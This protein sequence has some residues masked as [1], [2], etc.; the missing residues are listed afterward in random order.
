MKLKL[1]S[2]TV[3]F[4]CSVFSIQAQNKIN[5]TKASKKIGANYYKIIEAKKKELSTRNLEDLKSLKEYKHFG[6]W[7]SYWRHRINSDGSFPNENLGYFNAGIIDAT[8]K[9]IR[10]QKNKEL[11]STETWINIGAQDLP[12][13]NGYS[14]FPQMGRLNAFL[15]IKH[16]TNRNLDVLFVGAPSGGL[17]KS[18]D[19][20]TSWVPKLD[21]AASIG[22]SDIK[23]SPTT[24]FANYTTKPIYISTG[25]FDANHSK[26]IGI[27]KS[28]DGGETFNSTGLSFGVSA[29]ESTGEMHVFDDNTLIVGTTEIIKKTV[30]GGVTWTDSFDSGT[31]ATFLRIAVIGNKVLYTGLFDVFYTSDYTTDNWEIVVSNNNSNK[32]AVTVGED[33]NFYIQEQSGQIKKFDTTLKTFSNFG[34]I[35]VDYDSQDG[36][37]QALIVRNN[38][39]ISNEVNGLSS[40]DN[41][42]TWYRSL[43]GYYTPGDQTADGHGVFVHSDHHG[44]GKL[45]GNYEFWSVNDGGL[46]YITYNSPTDQT[47]INVYKTAKVIVNQV[48]AVAINSTAVDDNYIMANQDN[49]GFSKV[50]GNWYAINLGDGLQAAI[51]YNN[52]NI[53]YASDQNGNIIQTYTGFVGE[54]GG[55]GEDVDVP[56]VEFEFPLEMNKTNPNILYAGGGDDVYKIIDNSGL[57]ISATNAGIGK[58]VAIA[59]HGNAVFAVGETGTKFSSNDT[60]TWSSAISTPTGTVNSLDFDASNNAIRYITLSGYINGNKVFK[61]VDGGVNWINISGNLPNIVMKEV[62]LKQNEASEHLF[63]AT[64]LGV[65]HSSNGGIKWTKLGKGLPNVD[66]RD[67]DIHYTADKLVAATFGRGIWEINIVNA[68]LGVE[69]EK[70]DENFSFIVY[71][72]PV[73]DNDLHVKINSDTEFKF[74]IYNVVGGVVKKGIL[75]KATIDVSSLSSNLYMIRIFDNKRSKTIKFIK[76]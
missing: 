12:N 22:V 2:L 33:N 50:G 20:G 72:N 34:T 53:R 44:M 26:S 60:S 6:R 8:G 74:E 29:Q 31:N 35:P 10:S 13:A 15:R 67:I 7:Q 76:K 3:F 40:A 46:N 58:I 57:S 5:Y 55:N 42:A 32:A 45:D 68:T 28:I 14:N 51:N 30:D 47:P 70:F 65:Y 38:L 75:N 17:W 61:T 59:T 62:L 27:L 64:E 49:D 11:Q 19:G 73:V 69:D 4:L 36:Y 66:V 41:G 23:T 25:D 43:N 1:T 24:T 18:I 71:P 9:L 16:P 39:I 52:P 63:V 21:E 37:N 48:Y 56:G 54:L